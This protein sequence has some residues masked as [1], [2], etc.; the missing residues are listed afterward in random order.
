MDILS[1]GFLPRHDESSEKSF[2]SIPLKVG[3]SDAPRDLSP[4]KG[5]GFNVPV[6]ASV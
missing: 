3:W 6:G 1:G 2:G 4:R 5:T